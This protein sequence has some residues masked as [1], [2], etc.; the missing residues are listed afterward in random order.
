[1]TKKTP[2]KGR[3]AS[4]S[5]KGL[6]DFKFCINCGVKLPNKAKKCMNCG[7]SNENLTGSSIVCFS[8]GAN[9]PFRAKYCRKCGAPADTMK[10]EEPIV[11]NSE[12][13]SVVCKCTYCGMETTVKFE[14]VTA[15]CPCCNKI[16]FVNEALSFQD[17]DK[18]TH[19]S[20]IGERSNAADSPNS[21]SN[22]NK[23]SNRQNTQNYNSNNKI[24]TASFHE[25]TPTGLA[26]E[27][28]KVIGSFIKWIFS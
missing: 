13:D 6:L 18:H 24:L 9:L 7:A 21:D 11:V 5:S 14:N 27:C 16:F 25:D 22:K 15:R 3:K 4:F 20:N 8:C 26:M 28:L 19:Y 1:M 2:H 12:A 10:K 23:F 17:E